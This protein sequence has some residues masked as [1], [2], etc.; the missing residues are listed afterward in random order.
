MLRKKKNLVRDGSNSKS[1]ESV[2][3]I[4]MQNDEINPALTNVTYILLQTQNV[5]CVNAMPSS[6]KS[7]N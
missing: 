6:D 7:W 3:T 1:I 5:G 4:Y 2:E